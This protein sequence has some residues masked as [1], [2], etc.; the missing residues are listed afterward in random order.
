MDMPGRGPYDERDS[1][2]AR[3]GELQESDRTYNYCMQ[4]FYFWA[5]IKKM[6]FFPL[7]IRFVLSLFNV[8]YFKYTF[9]QKIP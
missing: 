9:L 8:H 2:I 1:G 3:S 5:V 6:S 7:E 4:L